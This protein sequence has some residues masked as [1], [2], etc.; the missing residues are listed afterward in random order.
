MNEILAYVMGYGIPVGA[1]VLA[2]VAMVLA[3]G[4]ALVWPRYIVLGYVAILLL[5]PMSSTYGLE[6]A[7]DAT[8]V[9][10]KGTR[11]FF[12]SFLDMMIFGTWLMAVLYGR[13]FFRDREPLAPLMKFYLG[14]ALVF[15]GHVLV[16]FFDPER[17]LLWDFNGRG[18]I[19]IFWQGMLVALLLTVIKTEKD[20]KILIVLMLACVA[21]REAFGL[22]RYVFMGGDPQNAYANIEKLAV[23]IT[24]WDINDSVLAVFVL[25]YSA[26]KLLAER[27]QGWSARFG[28]L[29]LSLLSALTVVLS[30]RRTAQLG[31]LLAIVVLGW[32]LP[33]GR[34]WPV[35]LALALLVPLAVAVTSARTEGQ[36]SLVEKL[37][38]DVKTDTYS[39]H[40]RSRFYELETAWRTVRE[41]LLF[42]VG[43]S[44]SFEVWSHYGLEYHQGRY[45]YVHSGFGHVLLKTGI[46]GLA[47]FVGLFLTY[48]VF[49]YRHWRGLPVHYQALVA[50]SLAAFAAQMPN[51]LVGTP[52]GEIRTMMVLGLMLAIPF[53]VVAVARRST[54]SVQAEAHSGS[55]ANS[56]DVKLAGAQG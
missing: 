48:L 4:A 30:A 7:A 44:G 37:L 1:L 2:L 18:V 50:A 3:M 9:Y 23:K 19:N 47:M 39:D 25:A 41:N 26:W 10:V 16:G 43:P 21:G 17:I 38:I 31:L 54:A 45:D 6:N 8:I 46:V 32:L 14:F 28:Y 51:M 24:F 40:R 34:R 20:L 15:L 53:M 49:V 27:V 35:V 56:M 12:F 55:P 29:S 13:L 36:A 33:R 11:T 52:I 5:F 42:G 22:V